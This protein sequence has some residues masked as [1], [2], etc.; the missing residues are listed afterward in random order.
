MS[1]N[2]TDGIWEARA[3]RWL[4]DPFLQFGSVGLLFTV[5]AVLSATQLYA[6][7]TSL[8]HEASWPGLVGLRLL[9]WL[10]WAAMTPVIVALDAR[11]R[12]EPRRWWSIAG[13]HL[14]TALAWF[15]VQNA[16]VVALAPMV[17]AIVA[18]QPFPSAYVA[19]FIVRFTT[20]LVVYGSVLA[21]VGFLRDFLRRQALVR[22]LYDA[23]LRAL[24]A[25]VHPHFLFN[26]L[27]TVG[28]LVR[29]G[30]RDEAI[31]TLVALS[32]LLRRSLRQMDQ[33]EVPLSEELEF[34]EEYLA[35]QRA[36]FGDNLRVSLDV[37]AHAQGVH[38]PP[39]ILQPLVENAIRHGLD[40]DQEPGQ[41]RVEIR[42]VTP[43][44][45]MRVE[46]D[47]GSLADTA[48][49]DEPDTG[50]G[51]GLSNLRGRL[52]RLYGSDYSLELSPT[53]EGGTAVTIEIPIRRS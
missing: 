14:A 9:D 1:Q 3:Q 27:H 33:D 43:R 25:Q 52:G 6:N 34:L 12:R 36:R 7:W 41:V 26:T 8:G 47:G 48:R 49:D 19:R 24:R 51:I 21:V 29:T 2:R 4:G 42:A 28:G 5:I 10:M 15:T 40:L 31:G 44:L 39:L 16:V 23:Q 53:D 46:D 37:D 22:D 13:I 20:A 32:D 30:N 45:R 18:R 17:D 38:V 35:I 11:L 50:G